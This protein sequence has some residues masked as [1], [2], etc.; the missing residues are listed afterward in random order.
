MERNNVYRITI[1]D[2]YAHMASAIWVSLVP[3]KSNACT[4]A[5]YRFVGSFGPARMEGIWTYASRVGAHHA[6][7]AYLLGY[8]AVCHFRQVGC[9]ARHRSAIHITVK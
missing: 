3:A 9:M 4:L 5:K 2:H 1:L 6:Y 8:H 7:W